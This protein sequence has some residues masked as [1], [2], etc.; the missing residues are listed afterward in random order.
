MIQKLPLEILL[1]VIEYLVYDDLIVLLK[2]SALLSRKLQ[3]F[4]NILK[5]IRDLTIYESETLPTIYSSKAK[6]VVLFEVNHNT[7]RRV[8]EMAT[9]QYVLRCKDFRAVKKLSEMSR[10]QPEFKTTWTERIVLEDSQFNWKSHRNFGLALA[11]TYGYLDIAKKLIADGLDPTCSNNCAIKWASFYN[12]TEMV[13]ML[14]HDGRADPSTNQNSPIRFAAC[15]GNSEV[16]EALLSDSRVDPSAEDNFALRYAIKYNHIGVV[17][18]LLRDSRV[19]PAFGNNTALLIAVEC[20]S[21]EMV[22]LIL[23]CDSVNP[24]ARHFKII[25]I[26]WTHNHFE[27]LKALLEDHRTE[28][29]AVSML[30]K[31]YSNKQLYHKFE[32]ILQTLQPSINI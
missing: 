26:A 17:K 5:Q 2:T 23:D 30:D 19:D 29:N 28:I 25:N 3:S 12:H 24:N 8:L 16:V 4:S 31:K 9:E 11:A 27:I 18:A 7:P 22:R 6:R 1:A 21:L 15:L 20:G 32:A 14:L 13:K 10:Y